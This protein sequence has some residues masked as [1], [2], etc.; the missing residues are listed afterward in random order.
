MASSESERQRGQC[1]HLKSDDPHQIL[2]MQPIG[3]LRQ[4]SH[5]LRSTR[6]SCATIVLLN[7]H[8]L[9]PLSPLFPPYLYTISDDDGTLFNNTHNDDGDEYDVDD[10]HLDNTPSWPT[11]GS[12]NPDGPTTKCHLVLRRHMQYHHAHRIDEQK[13]WPINDV[14]YGQQQRPTK[15]NAHIQFS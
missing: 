12:G 4:S 8:L 5:V 2:L 10:G 9:V 1:G 13:R 11:F 15:N 6:S 14:F 3:S 7:L